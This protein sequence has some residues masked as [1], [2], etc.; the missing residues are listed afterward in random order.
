MREDDKTWFCAGRLLHIS[1]FGVINR[2]IGGASAFAVEC[3][4][5]RCGA[6]IFFR[7]RFTLSEQDRMRARYVFGVQPDVRR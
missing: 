7:R 3:S 2:N 4:N 5:L 6:E 1:D